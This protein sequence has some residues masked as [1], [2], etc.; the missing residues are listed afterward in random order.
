[1]NA[2]L[3]NISMTLSGSNLTHTSAFPGDVMSVTYTRGNVTVTN[4]VIVSTDV[5]HNEDVM[6]V[7]MGSG[8]MVI[9]KH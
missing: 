4:N 2:G 6:R 1:M 7:T 9:E 8:N 5:N 3:W